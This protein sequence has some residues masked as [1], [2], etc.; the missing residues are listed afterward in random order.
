MIGTATIAALVPSLQAAAQLIP[1]LG[2]LGIARTDMY[3]A[4][5]DR[6][7]LTDFC[8]QLGVVPLD[9]LDQRDPA[10]RTFQERIPAA[11]ARYFTDRLEGKTV[12][13]VLPQVEQGAEV[14][15]LLKRAGG[16][17]G[18]RPAQDEV[19][20]VTVPL[21]AER[22]EVITFLVQSGAVSLRKEIITEIERHDV[23]LVREELVIERTSTDGRTPA[24]TIR[25]PLQHEEVRVVKSVVVTDEVVIRR[26]QF[27]EI[28]HIEE[29]VRYEQANVTKLGD[30]V[31][32]E[33]SH[34]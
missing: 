30:V 5:L 26:Q 8:K 21:R 31:M 32:R 17:F 14:T 22:L 11:R 25:I 3:V 12:L 20:E 6:R 2:R 16:D 13:L 19:R 15:R 10:T 34:G 23:T 7:G 9:V 27:E 29:A 1:E 4:S 18:P 33:N 24:E 28:R